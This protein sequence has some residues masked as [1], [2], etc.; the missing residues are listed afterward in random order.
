[1]IDIKPRP[2]G[3]V[4]SMSKSFLAKS[5]WFNHNLRDVLFKVHKPC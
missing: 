4:L 2:A 1:M 5:G 3:F